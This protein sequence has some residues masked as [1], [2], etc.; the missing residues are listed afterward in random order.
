MQMTEILGHLYQLMENAQD[1][2]KKQ[3]LKYAIEAIDLMNKLGPIFKEV[4]EQLKTAN[5]K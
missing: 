3:A 1:K 5:G 2:D 4:S